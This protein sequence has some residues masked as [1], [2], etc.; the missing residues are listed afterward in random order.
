MGAELDDT[1][2]R[3][4]DAAGQIFAEKGFQA[5]TIREICAAADANIAAVNYHFRDKEGLYHE[6]VKHANCAAG[7]TFSLDLGEG[8]AAR[9]RL[10]LYIKQFLA[11]L[12]DPSRPAWHQQLMMREM[13]HP[14][15][16]CKTVVESYI[17]PRANLLGSILAELLPTWPSEADRH[18]WA[19]SI[20]GQCLF[21]KVHRPIAVLLVGEEEY[22]GFTVDR[23]ADHI[24]AFSLAALDRLI[25][26]QMER[27]SETASS[28]S[29]RLASGPSSARAVGKGQS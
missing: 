28:A 25:E 27:P 15:A 17:R 9:E 13:A 6:A 1:R 11:N 3:L 2:R 10:R 21:Y 23:L 18:L 20:V 29:A 12:L 4:L 16:A 22:G 5:T 8:L 19:F 24:A 7:D 14:T 26:R